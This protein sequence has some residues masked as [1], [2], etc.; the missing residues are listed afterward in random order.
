MDKPDIFNDEIKV[1]LLFKTTLLEAS[2]YKELF[3]VPDCNINF[4]FYSDLKI[5]SPNEASV[6]NGLAPP[7]NDAKLYKPSIDVVD[8]IE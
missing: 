1:V 4:L 6:E 8:P 7:P 2:I 3:V 5:V